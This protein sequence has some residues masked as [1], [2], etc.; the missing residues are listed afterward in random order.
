M[1]TNTTLCLALVLYSSL[2]CASGGKRYTKMSFTNPANL[3]TLMESSRNPALLDGTTHQQLNL[4]LYINPTHYSFE[5]KAYYAPPPSSAQGQISAHIATFIPEGNYARR[6][7]EHWVIGFKISQPYVSKLNYPNQS[8]FSSVMG[9]ATSANIHVL[10]LSP[11]ISYRVNPMLSLGAGIDFAKASFK[12]VT[13]LSSPTWQLKN[14]LNAWGLGYHFGAL[15]NPWLGGFIGVSYFSKI[16]FNLKGTSAYTGSPMPTQIPDTQS[17]N[18]NARLT[19]PYVIHLNYFQALSKQFG[20]FFGTYYTHWSVF[21]R[22]IIHDAAPDPQGNTTI[23]STLYERN[24]WQY[25][26]GMRYQALD[27]LVLDLGVS[28]AQAPGSSPTPMSI[29][30]SHYWSIGLDAAYELN[31]WLTITVGYGHAFLGKHS[32]NSTNN[33][34]DTPSYIGH[35]SANANQFLIGTTINF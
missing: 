2:V 27:K 26:V 18:A 19:T 31:K 22:L 32:I 28:Y 5:G 10:N 35:V 23:T 3:S 24:T 25:S 4:Y 30:P 29:E 34:G 13:T 6:L 21:N 9:F 14:T 1:K 33:A 7:D 20:L 16:S 11:E 15:I 8:D 17:D 12:N